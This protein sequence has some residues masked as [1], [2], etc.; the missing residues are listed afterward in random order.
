MLKE[1]RS[2][3]PHEDIIYLGDTARVPYGTKSGETVLKYSIQNILF[4]LE[5]GVKAVVIA[6]NTASA[7]GLVSLQSHF[8]VP[9]LGVIRPGAK[10]AAALTRSK[11]VGVIGTE[12]TIRSQSYSKAIAEFDPAI[13]IVTSACPLLVSMAEEGWFDG[14]VARLVLEKYLA[15]FKSNEVDSLILGCTHYPLFKGVIGEVL[16]EVQLVDSGV[17]TAVWLKELL[18]KN[19]IERSGG[20]HHGQTTFYTTDLPERMQRIGHLF[21]GEEIKKVAKAEI[22]SL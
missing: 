12:G 13:Q 18:A 3:F 20:D 14:E 21:L 16:S 10:K 4:L 7:Y 2:L 1:I 5:C 6:C 8:S 11:K 22:S 17:E 15:P 19:G 9:V